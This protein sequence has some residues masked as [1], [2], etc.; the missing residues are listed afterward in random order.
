MTLIESRFRAFTQK[1]RGKKVIEMD[2]LFYEENLGISRDTNS[3][4]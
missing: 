2:T 4:F 3:L 1:R